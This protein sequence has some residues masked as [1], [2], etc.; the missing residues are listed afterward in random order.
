M[1]P[2]TPV[3]TRE[4]LE[5]QISFPSADGCQLKSLTQF[6]CQIFPP[7]SGEYLCIPFKRLFEECVVAAGASKNTPSRFEV[8]SPLTNS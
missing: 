6:Q 3:L 4:Q 5:R 8:T 1:A 7:G 2:P